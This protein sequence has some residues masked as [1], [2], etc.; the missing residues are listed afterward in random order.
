MDTKKIAENIVKEIKKKISDAKKYNKETNAVGWNRRSTSVGL[1]LGLKFGWLGAKDEKYIFYVDGNEKAEL[2]YLSDVR[3]LISHVYTLLNELKKTR[4][5]GNLAIATDVASFGMGWNYTDVRYPS[6][7][8]LPENPCKDFKAIQ[9]FLKKYANCDLPDFKLFSSAMGGKRGRL[10]DEYGDRCYLANK[11]NKCARVLAELRKA[12]G[13][14]DIVTY[15]YGNEDYID[16]M[17]R[18]HS[19][20]YEVECDG[21]KREYIEVTIK[22]PQGKVKYQQKIY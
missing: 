18:R 14:K 15:K 16:E 6:K 17:E 10:W 20:Y 13:A 3:E 7:V 22:T 9:S 21:E 19:E 12:K 1:G 2:T 11:P 4:G 8:A 5:W